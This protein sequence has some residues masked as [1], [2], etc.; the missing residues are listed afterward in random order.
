MSIPEA[1]AAAQDIGAPQT[2]LTHLTH[3]TDHSPAEAELP[4]GIKFAYD[5]LRLNL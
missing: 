3:Y 1:I 5:G 4:D 2:W